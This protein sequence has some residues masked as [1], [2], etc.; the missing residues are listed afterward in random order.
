M[1]KIFWGFM[2]L[3]FNFTITIGECT[4]GLIPDFAGY[5]LLLKGIDKLSRETEYFASYRTSAI[6]MIVYSAVI[7]TM[8][9]IGV[10]ITYASETMVGSGQWFLA[11][12]LNGAALIL[13][14]YLSKGI[15][16]GVAVLENMYGVS[17]E[18]AKL[19][20]AWTAT[21][22]MNLIN[23][24]ITLMMS[25]QVELIVVIAV[26]SLIIHIVFLV[27]L[28]VSKNLYNIAHDKVNR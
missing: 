3:F 12:A 13:F 17:F 20:G 4:I 9:L 26:A 24:I 6:V 25:E 21:M 8:E 15:V 10:P 27:R 11:S 19:K 28:D 22:C 1:R 23:F 7:Y 2:F 16:G 18:A 5:I 14:L